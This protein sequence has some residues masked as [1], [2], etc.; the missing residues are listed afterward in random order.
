MKHPC[1][2]NVQLF[3]VCLSSSRCLDCINLSKLWDKF[4]NRIVC[5]M[6]FILLKTQGICTFKSWL[7]FFYFCLVQWLAEVAF[8]AR[9]L[10]TKSPACHTLIKKPR[11]MNNTSLF[12]ILCRTRWNLLDTVNFQKVF[13]H[14]SITGGSTT[15]HIKRKKCYK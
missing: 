9:Y 8:L 13:Q 14:L 11:S 10:L 7:G 5:K 15:T 6:S 3:K 4:L 12:Y 1:F 2:W